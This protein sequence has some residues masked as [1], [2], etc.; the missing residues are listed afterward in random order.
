MVYYMDVAP[1]PLACM[2]DHKGIDSI[3]LES[4]C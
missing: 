3:L 1:I 4:Q 2:G